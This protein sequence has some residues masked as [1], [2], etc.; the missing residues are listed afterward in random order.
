MGQKGGKD[1]TTGYRYSFSIL[2]GICRGPVD[3]VFLVKADGKIFYDQNIADNGAAPVQAPDLFGGDKGQGGLLGTLEFYFGRF[4]QVIS[5]TSLIRRIMVGLRVPQMRGVLTTFY[6]GRICSNDP[7]PKAWQYR[8]RRALKGWHNDEC[9]YPEKAVIRLYDTSIPTTAITGPTGTYNDSVSTTLVDAFGNPT[10]DPTAAATTVNTTYQGQ[11]VTTYTSGTG[12][13]TT[14]NVPQFYND[15]YAM[16]PAHIIYECVTNPDWGRGLARELVDNV[17]FANAANI[18]YNEGFGLCMKWSQQEDISAFVQTVIDHIGAAVYTNPI[19]GLLSI[20]LIRADYVIS[21]LPVFDYEHGLLEVT[22]VQTAASDAIANEVIVKYRSPVLDSDREARAQNIAVQN[23]L[24]NFFTVT[25]DYSG[26]PTSTLAL[27]AAARELKINSGGWKRVEFKVDRRGYSIVPGDVFRLTVPDRGIEGMVVR[28]ATVD[29]S[30]VKDGYITIVG[31]QDIFGWPLHAT[32]EPQPSTFLEINRYPM[33]SPEY[34]LNM[35]TYRD[36]IAFGLPATEEAGGEPE[37]GG[38]TWGIGQLYVTVMAQRPSAVSIAYAANV[39]RETVDPTSYDIDEMH[40]WKT[41]NYLNFQRKSVLAQDIGV[42]DTTFTITGDINPSNAVI[43]GCYFINAQ[44]NWSGWTT[45]IY[46]Q[47]FVRLDAISQNSI[48]GVITVTVARGCVDTPAIKHLKGARLWAYDE[49]GGAINEAFGLNDIVRVQP[50]T[51]TVSMGD[52]NPA[53]LPLGGEFYGTTIIASARAYR[54]YS[55]AGFR[56]NGYPRDQIPPQSGD[57]ALTWHHRNRITQAEHLIGEEEANIT[58]EPD[59][60]YGVFIWATQA[61]SN[62]NLPTLLV[63]VY[64]N[65][66]VGAAGW[67]G[68]HGTPDDHL[69]IERSVLAANGVVTGPMYL[70]LGTYRGTPTP[71]PLY[72]GFE[73]WWNAQFDVYTD[74]FR[75]IMDDVPPDTSVGGFSYDFDNNFTGG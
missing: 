17:S 54:P 47:E 48:T 75:Y 16:N 7:Y 64:G 11:T 5:F 62:S 65:R 70:M 51:H 36:L 41:T 31:T 15:I 26:I 13:T 39:K 50:L 63:T 53:S 35:A 8:V 23:S 55:G 18:L 37:P 32:Q 4:D 58:P 60:T 22:S 57:L 33:M 74:T 42:T 38:H 71:D 21:S 40:D 52:L 69:T 72:H 10:S 30:Q 43:G 73:A 24:G 6:D 49:S 59:T 29:Q 9:W 56:V 14:Y 1:V 66:Y 46:P 27:K 12:I 34:N 19:T 3:S 2:A 20:K 61:G 68:T 44:N 45:S 67:I 28:V 25:K